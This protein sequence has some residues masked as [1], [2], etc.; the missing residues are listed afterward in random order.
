M[1]LL[2]CQGWQGTHGTVLNCTV[3]EGDT[4][5]AGWLADWQGTH[6][7]TVSCGVLF[8]WLVAGSPGDIKCHMNHIYVSHIISGVA[9]YT[10]Y[11][12]VTVL[13]W[14]EGYMAKYNEGNL[15][16][17]AHRIFEGSGYLYRISGLKLKHRQ[18]QF[19]TW[20]IRNCFS[21]EGNI[22]RV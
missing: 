2:S 1:S 8:D 11:N 17:R 16:G 18:Y 9:G 3:L 13:W 4:W 22:L 5:P 7:L 10:W 6:D 15:E 21:W 19:Q 14:E 12:A 20:Y